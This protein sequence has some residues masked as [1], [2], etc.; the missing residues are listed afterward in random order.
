MTTMQLVAKQLV[1]PGTW[2]LD[3][4]SLCT[5]SPGHM[6]ASNFVVRELIHLALGLTISFHTVK[7][8]NVVNVS[9]TLVNVW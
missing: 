3:T 4:R 9:F 2:S 6:V 8:T 7:Q 1:A 5:W